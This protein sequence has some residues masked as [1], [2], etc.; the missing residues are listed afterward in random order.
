VDV[1]A[2]LVDDDEKRLPGGPLVEDLADGHDRFV[3]G[4]L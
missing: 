3:G 2:D 1:L 4:F